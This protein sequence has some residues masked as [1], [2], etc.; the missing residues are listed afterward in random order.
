MML[1]CSMRGVRIL[2]SLGLP[3]RPGRRFLDAAAGPI[4]PIRSACAICPES[5]LNQVFERTLP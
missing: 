4:N 1:L 3:W 5:M 2:A